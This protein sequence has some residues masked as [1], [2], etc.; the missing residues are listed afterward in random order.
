MSHDVLPTPRALSMIAQ[1]K[2]VGYWRLGATLGLHV[3]NCRT[4]K[5]FH[6]VHHRPVQPLQGWIQFIS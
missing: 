2:P 5:E 1:G 3:R 6:I 4:L